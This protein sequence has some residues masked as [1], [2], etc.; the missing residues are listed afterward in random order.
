MGVMMARMNK[1]LGPISGVLAVV[2][3][4]GLAG[5]GSFGWQL[6]QKNIRLSEDNT[7]L[8]KLLKITQEDLASTTTRLQNETNRT[9]YLAEQVSTIASS[10]GTLEKLSRTDK[11]LLKKYSKVYFLNEHYVPTSLA[12][13]TP[14]FLSNH[15]SQKIHAGV[16]PYLEKMLNDASTTGVD[17]RINSAYRSFGT[18]AKIKAGYKITYGAGTANRFSADQGYSEHQLGTTVDFDTPSIKGDFSKFSQTDAFNWLTANAYRYG[19]IM[20]YPKNNTYYQYEPWHWRFVGVALATKLHEENK[21]FYDYPQRLIDLY[22]IS[23]FD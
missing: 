15:E 13:I 5:G 19:F 21:R 2:L 4:A 16:W 20:S 11:E 6:Y 10:V 12:T 23:I 3:A 8:Q 18:Q 22:L 17:L 14:A 7:Q 1:F 9:N